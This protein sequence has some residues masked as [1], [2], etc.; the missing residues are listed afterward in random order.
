VSS[1]DSSQAPPDRIQWEI[2]RLA[3]AEVDVEAGQEDG[4]W[5]MRFKLPFAG[6]LHDFKVLFPADYPEIQPTIYGPPGMLPRHQNPRQGSLCLVDNEVN[7]WRPWRPALDLVRQLETL[8]RATE[9]GH[10]S[11]VAQEA[12]MAEPLT[13]HL[14]YRDD[15]TVLVPDAL[16]GDTIG[17]SAGTFRLLRVNKHLHVIAEVH[18]TARKK[19]VGAEEA[20]LR[21]T[22]D[23]GAV[24]GWVE[25]AETPTVADLIDTLKAGSR[26]ALETRATWKGKAKDGRR[27]R[28]R[29]Q[30]HITGITF[31]EEGP[32][33]G[34]R[35]RTWVFADTEVGADGSVLWAED[36]PI[37]A[38]A[39]SQP[40]RLQ[41]IPELDGL[42][43]F[44]VVLVGA[45][46]LGAQVA[47]ELA[48]GGVGR[49]E[50][51]DDDVYE[52]GNSVR[53]V[54]PVT[55]AGRYKAHAVA[56]T[57]CDLNPY[58]HAR[59]HAATVG[60]SRGD[61]AELLDI[62][63]DADLIIE[64]TGSHTVTRLLRRRAR[65]T[66]ATVVTAA[67]SM[68]GFGGRVVVLRA[69]G[70]CWDCFLRAQEAGT[71]PFPEEGPR[72]DQT[73]FGCSHPAASCAGF[74]VAHLAAITARMSIQALLRVAYPALDH[75]WTVVNFRPGST[76]VQQGSLVAL[77]DCPMGM[78]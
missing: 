63:A 42:Q 35:R 37:R 8:L 31:F 67:L 39:I 54:L 5:V 43:A 33:Q 34:E 13:G 72:H 7:W 28:R 62:V 49:L 17:A 57:C 21:L 60:H 3:D 68:G 6:K 16:L 75:D 41:R 55:A 52:P 23:Q 44:R 53:H 30:S 51:Y 61:P 10:D 58:C 38:Q 32:R 74:D 46:S 12:P 73:P 1:G 40:Q 50:I 77:P 47:V 15:L 70:P 65:T 18:D 27:A 56:D 45:G 26:R 36:R 69:G 29:R 48:K 14:P 66:G 76:P 78:H 25:L 24:G 9:E 2:D 11:V 4:L 20:I 59:G 22:T 64:T 71:I 19:I